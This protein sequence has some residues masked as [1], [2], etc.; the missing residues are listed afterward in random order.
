[1]RIKDA[2]NNEESKFWKFRH[3]KFQKGRPDLLAEIRKSNHNESADKQEVD[4]LK[5]EVGDLRDR[6]NMLSGD[7]D[8]LKTVVGS[9]MKT[10]QAQQAQQ[11]QAVDY[12]YKKRRLNHEGPPAVASSGG[13]NMDPYHPEAPPGGFAPS[14][15]PSQHMNE[16]V[17]YEDL[18]PIMDTSIEPYSDYMMSNNNN[19][20]MQPARRLPR[21]ESIGAASFSTQDG[22]ML[23]SLFSLDPMEDGGMLDFSTEQ[24]NLAMG[25]VGPADHRQ[26]VVDPS[27]VEKLRA[28]LAG[29]PMEMQNAFVDRLVAAVVE[30]E[31]FQKQVDAM[32]SLATSAAE[33]ACRRLAAAGRTPDDP[34]LVPLASAVLGAYLARYVGNGSVPTQVTLPSSMQPPPPSSG[35]AAHGGHVYMPL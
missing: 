17:V 19:M 21:G 32:A 8:K 12:S 25:S 9:L 24:F 13:F 20:M 6:M 31:I 14:Y 11:A 2:E 18:Q 29:M 30:P 3:E 34:K 10:K 4:T 26:G 15:V 5:C 7:M 23:N 33:E 35:H 22:H 16:K 28:S 27:L 1:L